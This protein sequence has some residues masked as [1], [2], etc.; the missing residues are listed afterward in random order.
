MTLGITGDRTVTGPLSPALLLTANK[1][2]TF[3]VEG[4]RPVVF[5]LTI[6][7]HTVMEGPPLAGSK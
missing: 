1:W 3:V 4:A 5:I 7:V 2:R 6:P